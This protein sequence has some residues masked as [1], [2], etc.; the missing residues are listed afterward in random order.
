M[1]GKLSV[2][3]FLVSTVMNICFTPSAQKSYQEHEIEINNRRCDTAENIA[4]IAAIGILGREVVKVAQK[5]VS[6]GE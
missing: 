4:A 5:A 2:A 3:S 1:F 6:E